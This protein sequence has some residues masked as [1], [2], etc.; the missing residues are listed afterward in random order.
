MSEK[1]IATIK[2]NRHYL[3]NRMA[4]LLKKKTA[5]EQQIATGFNVDVFRKLNIIEY[6]ITCTKNRIQ[7]KFSLQHVDYGI[8]I[9]VATPVKYRQ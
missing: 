2:E 8:A 1:N 5:L 4:M 7:G 3:H 9:G 6:S